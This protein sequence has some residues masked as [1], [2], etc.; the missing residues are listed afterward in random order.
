MKE[1]NHI[2]P[3]WLAYSFD[4]PVRRLFHNP[5][6]LFSPYVRP[7]MHVADIGCGMGYFSIG[8]ARIVGEEGRVYSVDIQQKMLDILV[9]RATRKKVNHLIHPRIAKPD[10]LN[11]PAELD[12]I[13][14]SWMVHETGDLQSFFR[15][16]HE[17]L[18]PG[19]LF[20][21]TEPKM[22]VS[23]DRF[24]NEVACA[25][26]ISFKIK[27]RPTVA[28]SHAIVLEKTS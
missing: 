1:C 18:N 16:I 15:Q 23:V 2:C 27:T 10:Q 21:M 14:A 20:Y 3:W 5:E 22:H 12:F 9:K 28:F 8:L 7:G 6:K 17:T 19:G 24:D 13:L 4:N 11:L 26:G 25:T